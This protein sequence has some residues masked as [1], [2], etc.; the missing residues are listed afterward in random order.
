MVL[1]ALRRLVSNIV[2]T[3]EAPES[4]VKPESIDTFCVTGEVVAFPPLLRHIEA[5]LGHPLVVLDPFEASRFDP[6]EAAPDP[7]TR[8]AFARAV[9]LSLSGHLY[10]PNLLH[11]RFAQ[12]RVQA[13]EKTQ[14]WV[15]GLF[16]LFA[17]VALGVNSWLGF[18]VRDSHSARA[19]LTKRLAQYVPPLELKD[20]QALAVKAKT[21]QEGV[22][23]LCQDYLCLAVIR[24]VFALTPPGVRLLSLDAELGAPSAREAAEGEAAEKAKREAGSGGQ[25]TGG[26]E[27]GGSAA[28]KPKQSSSA[29]A[30]RVVLEGVIPGDPQAAVTILTIYMHSL[31]RSLILRAPVL[32]E[33]VTDVGEGDAVL[34]FRLRV[35]LADY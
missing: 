16:A 18:R 7:A 29:K 14:W 13:T 15:V 6:G 2:R 30:N 8:S 3:L 26:K 11:T 4:E 24:E 17:A 5:S 27:G 19:D 32:E 33:T 1:P 21:E 12:E 25:G 10:T 22:A 20:I 28:P 23:R 35:S 34:R 31:D 9:G